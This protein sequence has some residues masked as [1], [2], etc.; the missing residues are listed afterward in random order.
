[1]GNIAIC[2]GMEGGL[3]VC[4]QLFQSMYLM[5]QFLWSEL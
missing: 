1:M 3:T 4:I 5:L 2:W